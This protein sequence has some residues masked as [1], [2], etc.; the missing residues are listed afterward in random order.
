MRPAERL[1]ERDPVEVAGALQ[2]LLEALFGQGINRPRDL[3]LLAGSPRP[4][5]PSRNGNSPRPSARANLP[6]VRSDGKPC[7]PDGR[8][9]VPLRL[10]ATGRGD[11]AKA[12]DLA[13]DYP[14]AKER[15][16]KELQGAGHLDWI[17]LLKP[18]SGTHPRAPRSGFASAPTIP[19]ASSGR[20][21]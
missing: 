14:W 18:F 16:E 20:A 12:R 17:P 13:D 3:A 4:V 21:P 8:G 7:A 15:L 10:G 19:S 5:A 2:L 11:P 6:V 1:Q 9:D